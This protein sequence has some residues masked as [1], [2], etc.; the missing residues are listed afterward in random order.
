MDPVVL[1]LPPALRDLTAGDAPFPGTLRAGDPPT[2]WTDA[3]VFAA[4]PA[5]AAVDAEHL[6]TA[7]DAAQTPDGPRV[8]LPHCPHPLLDVITTGALS[9]GVVVT[10]AVSMLRGATEADALGARTGRWWVT[11]SARPVLALTGDLEWRT[12][13]VTALESLAA[14]Q[15]E[16]LADALRR[17][18]A[19]AADPR[20]LRREGAAIEAGLFGLAAPA[21]LS[22]DRRAHADGAAPPR[23]RPTPA[24]ETAGL[25]EG[26]RAAVARLVDGGIADRLAGA[27][28]S[29][30]AGSRR[31]GRSTRGPR[32]PGGRRRVVLVAGVAAVAVVLAGALWPADETPVAS[33]ETRSAPWSGAT[34]SALP[35]SAAPS[36]EEEPDGLTGLG[37][38]LVDAVVAC[39]DDACA[40]ELW[41]RPELAGPVTAA[42]GAYGI[43]VVDEYGG[44]AALRVTGAGASQIVVIVQVDERWLVR[45]VYDLADQP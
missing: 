14:D 27:L 35:P 20:L 41:E 21:P 45:E 23:R 5:W 15:A 18:S 29:L 39:G 13:T 7:L 33:V 1:D 26:V 31:P 34:A 36:A 40:A 22:L 16:P 28:S 42:R 43:E 8:V 44:V 37:R 10:V 24:P 17:A 32:G 3:A 30:R 11:G 19:T 25:A 12:D 6:L 9:P 4:S 2:V 38:A